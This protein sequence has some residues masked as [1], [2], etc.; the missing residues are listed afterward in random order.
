MVIWLCFALSLQELQVNQE[1]FYFFWTNDDLS[2][3]SVIK[4]REIALETFHF[5]VY[6]AESSCPPT[7]SKQTPKFILFGFVFCLCT[8]YVKGLYWLIQKEFLLVYFLNNLI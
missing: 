7:A 2:G 6:K 1:V 4:G 8:R 3:K 5:W